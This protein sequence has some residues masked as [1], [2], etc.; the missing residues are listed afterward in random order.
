VPWVQAADAGREAA[1][2]RLL[3]YA[4]LGKVKKL[5]QLLDGRPDIR[6]DAFD[7]EGCTALHQA[8][9]YGRLEVARLLLGCVPP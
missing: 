7:A 9:R 2:Q 5:A 4:V 6:V 8:C 1:E 3:R